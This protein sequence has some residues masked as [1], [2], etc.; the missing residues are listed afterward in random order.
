LRFQ[1]RRNSALGA[2]PSIF[3]CSLPWKRDDSYQIFEYAC[4]EDNDAIC[5]YITSSRA[6]RA[7][8]AA[9]QK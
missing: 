6:R 2:P 1:P 7:Q 9:N 4:H 3:H 5:N 8:E